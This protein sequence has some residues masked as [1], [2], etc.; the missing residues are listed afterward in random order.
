MSLHLHLSKDAV[1]TGKGKIAYAYS[2]VLESSEGTTWK[3]CTFI[4]HMKIQ[5]RK[6]DG[7]L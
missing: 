1:S 3:T 7:R 4:E 5:F 6:H 2:N